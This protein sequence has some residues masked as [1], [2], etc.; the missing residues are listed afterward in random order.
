MGRYA[1][2]V[3]TKQLPEVDGSASRKRNPHL[4][5]WIVTGLVVIV[6]LVA[7]MVIVNIARSSSSGTETPAPTQPTQSA[8]ATADADGDEDPAEETENPDEP[9]SVEVG[10]T[11]DLPIQNWG[12]TAQVS[13]KFGNQVRY[14]FEGDNLILSSEVIDSLPDACAEMRQQWGIQKSGDS[15]SVLKPAERCSEAPELYD[16][17]WGLTAA[18]VDSIQ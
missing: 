3:T 7:S 12:V 13:S 17:I 8:S 5:P 1:D 18:A 14:T 11:F 4:L 6:A 9:P 16:E 2:P 10:S 15:Y